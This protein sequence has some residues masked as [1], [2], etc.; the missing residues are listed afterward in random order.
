MVK[1]PICGMEVDQNTAADRTEYQGQF[2]YFCSEACKRQFES[3]PELYIQ[4]ESTSAQ[5]QS[6]QYGQRS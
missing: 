5:S 6:G 3:E 4:H 2:Y 1:D